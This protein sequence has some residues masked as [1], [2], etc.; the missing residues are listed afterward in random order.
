MTKGGKRPGAGRPSGETPS[1]RV[2]IPKSIEK[3]FYLWKQ[4]I[5]AKIKAPKK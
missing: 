1:M 2:R 4:E 5:L 3:E